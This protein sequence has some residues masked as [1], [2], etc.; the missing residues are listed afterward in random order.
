MYHCTGGRKD[1]EAACCTGPEL[2]VS[3]QAA[4]MFGR[5][6]TGLLSVLQYIKGSGGGNKAKARAQVIALVL[7]VCLR[8]YFPMA[9][10]TTTTPFQRLSYGE[11][12]NTSP[13][14]APLG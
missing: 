14:S 1:E 8:W 3:G 13:E 4:L 2:C 5:C 10:T 7:M 12:E 9:M 6:R 11:G